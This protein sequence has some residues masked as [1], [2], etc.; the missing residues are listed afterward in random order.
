MGKL[1]QIGMLVGQGM[2]VTEAIQNVGI[3]ASTYYLWRANL[4][5]Q[6]ARGLSHPLISFERTSR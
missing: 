1:R 4:R 2:L 5:A 6:A 3:S